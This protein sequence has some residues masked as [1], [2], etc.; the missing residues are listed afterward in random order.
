MS[1]W[2]SCPVCFANRESGCACSNDKCPESNPD[3][4]KVPD[5]QV[6]VN[7]FERGSITLAESRKMA[8][9]PP[10]DG[11]PPDNFPPMAA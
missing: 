3:V 2:Y 9:L 10:R 5:P 8:G 7:L 6:A 4:E 11:L 1:E